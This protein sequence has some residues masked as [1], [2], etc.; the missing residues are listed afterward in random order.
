M[1]APNLEMYRSDTLAEVGTQSNPIDFGLCNAGETTNLSYDILLYNDKD[2]SQNSDDAKNVQIELRRMLVTHQWTSNG[3]ASQQFTVSYT[4]ML[5][6]P[7]YPEEVTVDDV[8]WRRVATFAG[9]GPNDTV[10]Q[11]NR[12][13]G[14][15]LFGNGV[16]GK[17][18]PNGSTIKVTYIPDLN[19][20]GKTVYSNQWISVKSQ[21]VVTNEIH[22]SVEESTKIDNNTVEVLHFPYVTD[23]IGVW[24]NVSKTGTNYYTGGSF[25]GN[26]GRITLGTPLTSSTPYVEYKY[27]IKDDNEATYTPLGNEE[28]HSF[29][30]RIPKQNAKRLKFKVDVP[31][32][33][34]TEGGAYIK[35]IF[36]IYYEF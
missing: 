20:F 7:D 34:S 9:L 26:T 12:T 10:Y 31:S 30:N 16:E 32:S 17:I 2:G 11:V 27:Q 3:S 29:D 36:R 4:P 25:D 1:G 24:D 14:T 5:D 21:G 15:I 8:E 6:D 35:A 22:I 18:P 19:T 28:I 23:V 13:T 33:A